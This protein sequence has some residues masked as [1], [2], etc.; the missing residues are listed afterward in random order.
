VRFASSGRYAIALV[1]LDLVVGGIE[2]KAP[3]VELVALDQL[4]L[5]PDLT[6]KAFAPQL[7]YLVWSA[8][9]KMRLLWLGKVKGERLKGKGLKTFTLY[10]A[11]FPLVCH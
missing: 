4:I 1:F 3:T 8:N 9:P 6:V 5:F 2:F 7:Q 10:P 11:K